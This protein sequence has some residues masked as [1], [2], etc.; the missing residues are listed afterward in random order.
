MNIDERRATPTS[1]RM[2]LGNHVFPLLHIHLDFVYDI[3]IHLLK[4]HEKYKW[5]KTPLFIISY[6]N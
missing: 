4:Y 2:S 5:E 1:L 3:I 6:N